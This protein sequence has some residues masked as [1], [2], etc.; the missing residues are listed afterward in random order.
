[1]T[2]T[3]DFDLSTDQDVKDAAAFGGMNYN[4][5]SVRLGISHQAVQQCEMR[6]L[7]KLR[8]H[9]EIRGI[10]FNDLFQE[11]RKQ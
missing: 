7:A 6:A 8:R 1:M 10:S 2:D 3:M 5:I 4:E 11:M 9:C